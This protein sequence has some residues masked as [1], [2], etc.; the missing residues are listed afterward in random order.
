MTYND[1]IIFMF[2]LRNTL[3]QKWKLNMCDR[4]KKKLILNDYLKE[5]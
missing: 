3:K 2:S 1:K 4:K 5:M